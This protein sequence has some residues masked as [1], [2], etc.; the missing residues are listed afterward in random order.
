MNYYYKDRKEFNKDSLK[1]KIDRLLLIGKNDCEE[2]LENYAKTKEYS[3]NDCKERNIKIGSLLKGE[4]FYHELEEYYEVIG[5]MVEA[6]HDY[7]G[8]RKIEYGFRGILFG[9]S[10]STAPINFDEAE[11][12]DDYENIPNGLG[13]HIEVLDVLETK[14]NVNK[15]IEENNIDINKY[16]KE[17]NMY[18]DP[19]EVEMIV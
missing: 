11:S 2:F 17:S 19:K 6:E 5:F 15:C 16:L 12:L 8:K 1:E 4:A 7:N 13:D 9:K 14:E 10:S 18:L 3:I